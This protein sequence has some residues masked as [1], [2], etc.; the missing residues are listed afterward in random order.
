MALKEDQVRVVQELW[1]TQG[2][3]SRET[4]NEYEGEQTLAQCR[5]C[6]PLTRYASRESSTA[7]AQHR[8]L[9]HRGLRAN[10]LGWPGWT[11]AQ[12]RRGRRRR[13]GCFRARGHWQHDHDDRPHTLKGIARVRSR[14][15]RTSRAPWVV[16]RVERGERE[17]PSQRGG[18]ETQTQEASVFR[19]REHGMPGC[20]E[21]ESHKNAP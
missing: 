4:A 6:V 12:Q 14:P 16:C 8:G 20:A 13:F 5:Q 3:V 21:V 10:R 15:H 1:S 17:L 7:A 19:E 2:T 11:R 9:R 18:E